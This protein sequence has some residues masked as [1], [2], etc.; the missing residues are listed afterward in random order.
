MWY[1]SCNLIRFQ[2]TLSLQYYNRQIFHNYTAQKGG[3]AVIFML[4]FFTRFSLILTQ[5]FSK[6]PQQVVPNPPLF[7][8]LILFCLCR[9][10]FWN[11]RRIQ[12]VRIYRV[13]LWRRWQISDGRKLTN[14]CTYNSISRHRTIAFD[15]MIDLWLMGCSSLFVLKLAIVAERSQDERGRDRIQGKILF[16]Q[17]EIKLCTCLVVG[18]SECVTF[19]SST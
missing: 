3:N 13:Q 1:S 17:E 12:K 5:I 10:N 11:M 15:T 6:D 16:L 9:P 8:T 18:N 4:I 2:R 7:P 19:P 14:V